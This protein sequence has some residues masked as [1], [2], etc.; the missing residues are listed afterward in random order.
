MVKKLLEKNTLKNEKNEEKKC[1][2][3]KEYKI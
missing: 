1:K 2:K 3:V